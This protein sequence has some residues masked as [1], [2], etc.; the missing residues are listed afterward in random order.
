MCARAR[1][2]QNLAVRYLLPWAH[3]IERAVPTWAWRTRVDEGKRDRSGQLL[4]R[5]T[6]EDPESL[7]RA[8]MKAAAPLFEV[9]VVNALVVR[10]DQLNLGHPFSEDIASTPLLASPG[11]VQMFCC[12]GSGLNGTGDWSFPPPGAADVCWAAAH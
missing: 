9:C 2:V 8:Y 1:L 11:P 12:D 7:T 3:S 5:S 6:A 10:L 4:S